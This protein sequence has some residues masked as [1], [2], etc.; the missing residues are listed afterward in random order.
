MSL[1]IDFVCIEAYQKL[2]VLNKQRVSHEINTK[3]WP[4]SYS[5]IIS[6]RKLRSNNNRQFILYMV[7]YDERVA[8]MIS[9]FRSM[10]KTIEY[11][12]VV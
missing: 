9:Y 12:H 8:V 7:N 5:H 2:K 11:I 10:A 4:I 1:A 6:R 3:H